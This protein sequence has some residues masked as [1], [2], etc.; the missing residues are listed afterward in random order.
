MWKRC[1]Q[2][3]ML[4]SL[5]TIGIGGLWGCSNTPTVASHTPEEITAVAISYAGMD[6]SVNYSF[7]LR[8]EADTWLFDA[9]C[10]IHQNEVETELV[11]CPI[12]A[13]EKDACMSI[14]VENDTITYV[15]DHASTKQNHAADAESTSIV[16]TFSD[17]TQCM[18]SGTQPAL[19][20]FFYSLAETYADAG[21]SAS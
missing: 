15:E 3:A 14:L 1:I 10:F 2:M 20:A 11:G 8:N 12:T 16:L 4:L 19:G 17:G 21:A 13:E 5:L 18:A 6:R 7:W 9:T